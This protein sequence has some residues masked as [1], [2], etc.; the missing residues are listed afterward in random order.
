M[1]ESTAVKVFIPSALH[2]YTSGRDLVTLQGDT[3]E[4]V[5][6]GL[7]SQFP[8]LRR[9]L[10]DDAGH[11]RQFVNIYVNDQDIRYLKRGETRLKDGDEVRIIP[12][13]AGG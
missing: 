5:L 8:I 13:V 4:R 7:I 12:A 9:H 1:E 3:V 2:S 10:F 11:L 6:E